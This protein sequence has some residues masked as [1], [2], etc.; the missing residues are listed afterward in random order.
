MHMRDLGVTSAKALLLPAVLQ[1]VSF[2]DVNLE[3]ACLLVRVLG[4][5]LIISKLHLGTYSAHAGT[6]TCG[7]N[8]LVVLICTKKTLYHKVRLTHKH[9]HYHRC[10]STVLAQDLPCPAGLSAVAGANAP[11]TSRL[12]RKHLLVLYQHLLGHMSVCTYIG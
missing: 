3:T 7:G 5:M 11:A 4:G 2:L 9:S 12:Q 6:C 8:Q 10:T 1:H